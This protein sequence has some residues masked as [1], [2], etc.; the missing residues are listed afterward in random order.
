MKNNIMKKVIALIIIAIIVT[1]L[2]VCGLGKKT[3]SKIASG[4]EVE[5]AVKTKKENKDE[6][7]TAMHLENTS[8]KIIVIVDENGDEIKLSEGETLEVKEK[9]TD[10]SGEDIY[11]LANG[12]SVK[13]EKLI[14]MTREVTVN[15]E[16]Y[17]GIKKNAQQ[18]KET[19]KDV[20]NAD[21]KSTTSPQKENVKTS[22]QTQAQQ[23]TPQQSVQAQ[24][25]AQPRSVQQQSQSQPIEQQEQSQPTEQQSQSQ[26]KPIEPQTEAPKQANYTGYREDLDK[27]AAAKIIE[28]R[29]GDSNAIKTPTW[30]EHLYKVAQVRAKE[31]VMNFSHDSVSNARSGYN[32]AEACHMSEGFGMT[33]ADMVQSAID[34]WR[35][36]QEH[37]DILTDGD[38]YA[39][40]CCQQGNAVYW[41]FLCGYNDTYI[42]ENIAAI[43]AIEWGQPNTQK[44]EEKYQK[45]YN[46]FVS[47]YGERKIW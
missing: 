21:E 41:V 25:E 36:S 7:V 29:N 31:L 27:Q 2:T 17:N 39:V 8:G 11:I 15:S 14:G 35:N 18:N 32:I 42:A 4:G 44:Y 9:T 5:T 45:Y 30:N 47:R 3:S 10:K 24:T 19:T 13:A 33:D 40:A 34:G 37:Y 28:L 22:S 43:Q 38:Q 26:P 23:S 12:S 6:T 46:S 20:V 1:G 16:M